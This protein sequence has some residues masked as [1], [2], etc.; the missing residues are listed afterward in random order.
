MKKCDAVLMQEAPY[1][2]MGNVTSEWVWLY[3]QHHGPDTGDNDSSCPKCKKGSD[4]NSRY[5]CTL[6]GGCSRN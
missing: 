6:F 1:S 5:T 4:S 3:G 2:I